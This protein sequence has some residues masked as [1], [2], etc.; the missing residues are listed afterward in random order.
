MTTTA[1]SV[2]LMDDI[3][4]FSAPVAFRSKA[5]HAGNGLS[6]CQVLQHS[7]GTPQACPKGWPVY[8]HCG[9]VSLAKDLGHLLQD[10]PSHE[11]RQAN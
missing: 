7:G 4:R 5:R 10:T 9:V 6:P 8:A 11:R 2:L 1:N 3:S